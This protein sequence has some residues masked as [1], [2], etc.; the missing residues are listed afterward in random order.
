MTSGNMQQSTISNAQ[1]ATP[2]EEA[3]CCVLS[4]MANSR[5]TWCGKPHTAFCFQDAG[6]AS[7]NGLHKGRLIVCRGCRDAIVAALDNGYESTEDGR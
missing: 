3:V 1:E 7:L 5:A 4:G 6:H 2:L